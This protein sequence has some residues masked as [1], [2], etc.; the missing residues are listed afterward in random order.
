MQ[1]IEG[2]YPSQRAKIRLKM[3]EL[4]LEKEVM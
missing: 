4:C 1:L 3:V 2:A